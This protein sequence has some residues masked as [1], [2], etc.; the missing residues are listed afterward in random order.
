VYCTFTHCTP[1]VIKD[2]RLQR[3]CQQCGRFHD[4]SAFEGARKSCRDQLNKHNARRRLKQQVEQQKARA[5]ERAA[6]AP[7]PVAHGGDGG[8]PPGPPGAAA[9]GPE[10]GGSGSDLSRLLSSLMQSPQ[11]LQALR[12]LLGFPTNAAM[13]ALKPYSPQS[14]GPDM[15]PVDP[16]AGETMTDGLAFILIESCE[17]KHPRCRPRRPCCG[18]GTRGATKSPA[19]MSLRLAWGVLL[20][21]NSRL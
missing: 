2:S 21:R 11:Q 5:A 9:A 6:A 14:D 13:P 12:L 20:L 7:P 1:Q 17:H 18:R 19:T 10:G 16:S 4:V 3:F 8:E 15:G